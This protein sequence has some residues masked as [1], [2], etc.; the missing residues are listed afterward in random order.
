MNWSE[1]PP[2][3]GVRV[4]TDAG[5]DVGVSDERGEILVR[6]DAEPDALR[7]YHARWRATAVESSGHSGE[8][9]PVVVVWMAIRP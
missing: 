1:S 2:V 5:R 4:A 9:L 6:L 8:R 3:P 7:L